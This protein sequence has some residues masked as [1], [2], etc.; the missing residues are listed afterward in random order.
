VFLRLNYLYICTATVVLLAVIAP[1]TAVRAGSLSTKDVQV[2]A[3]VL[4]FLDP[5]CSDG[6]VAVVYS[7]GNAAS[8]ADAAEI[9]TAFGSGLKAG[10]NTVRAVAVDAAELGKGGSYVALIVSTAAPLDPV[11]QFVRAFRV[12]C[13]T[14]DVAQVQAGRCVMA[15]HS[16][17]RVDIVLNHDLAAAAGIAFATAFRML[18]HEI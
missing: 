9:V 16:D 13:I 11:M 4:G 2:I 14:G 3:K 17:P 15:V 18:V 12:P 6:V 7:A 8:R 1:L 10:N 5:P